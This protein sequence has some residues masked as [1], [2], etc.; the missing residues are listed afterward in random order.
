MNKQPKE[1]INLLIVDDKLDNV[2]A[3]ESA[4]EIDQL[5]VYTSVWPK[6][7][8]DICIENNITIALIDVKMPGI[9]GFELLDLLKSDPR[10]EHIFVILITGFSTDSEYVVK[11]LTK[12]AVDYLFKPLDLYITIAKVKSL[13]SLVEYQREINVKN[14]EL[15][16][17]QQELVK[18]IEQVEKSKVLKEN[19]LANMSHEIRTPLNGIIGLTSFLSDS[20]LT[21]DQRE[22]VEL[23]EYSSHS[24]LGIVND[25][26]ESAQ[27]DAGKIEIRR[28]ATNIR[29]L[30]KNVCDLSA[31]L[32]KD[33]GLELICTTDDS[34]PPVLM[35]DSLRI[36]Q[37]LINLVNNAI[38]FTDPGGSVNV[39]IRQIEKKDG[40]AFLEYVVKDTGKGIPESS[41]NSIFTRFEQIEDKT[42][43]KFGGNG[44]GLSIVKRLV[45]LMG[46][47]LKVESTLGVGTSFIFTNTYQEVCDNKTDNLIKK[48]ISD[49]PKF[50]NIS[51]LLAEDNITNQFIAVKMLKEWNI[52]VEVA[53]NG[54]E[55][56]EK[57]KEKSYDLVLMDTHMPLMDGLETTKKIRTEIDPPKNHVPIISFSA[58]VLEREKK[59]A[60][61]AGADDFVEKP[62]EPAVLNSK[63]HEILNA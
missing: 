31:T 14:K 30:L 9:D 52:N 3:L 38:K 16:S 40:K 32:A 33:K 63:I 50:N 19:F 5:N 24:L 60:R 35:A 22:V 15:E 12:G 18:A 57:F 21:K 29:E 62:F 59:D 41:I 27:I 34:V 17:Y 26:L 53:A 44:L 54:L 28:S 47:I 36:S 11:G 13:M 1:K 37:V 61:D 48:P 56:L 4:L 25:V 49:L 20:E 39:S 46:G 6:S 43:Q 8:F 10:T 23:M 55:A 51:V 58:S 7:A 42:W 45:E 2:A